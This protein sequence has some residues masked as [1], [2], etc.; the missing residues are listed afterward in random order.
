MEL[1]TG[2]GT[3]SD[4]LLN[5]AQYGHIPLDVFGEENVT[6]IT[7]SLPRLLESDIKKTS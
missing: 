5:E 6:T 7:V 2:L 1:G 4:R 3:Y